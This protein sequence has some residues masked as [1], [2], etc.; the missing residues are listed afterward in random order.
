LKAGDGIEVKTLGNES[1]HRMEV[2][3][4]SDFSVEEKIEMI[5]EKTQKY[6]RALK[7]IMLVLDKLKK[8]SPDPEGL[9]ENLRALYGETRKKATIAK[10]AVTELM[11]KQRALSDSFN[12]IKSAEVLVR[13]TLYRGVKIF[14]G[15]HTYEPETRETKVKITYNHESDKVEVSRL[16]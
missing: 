5:Q 13:D 11:K 15:K 2:H 10:I 12:E 7:K 14:F 4:G 8:V 16:L 6:E 1:E 9:P 3:A